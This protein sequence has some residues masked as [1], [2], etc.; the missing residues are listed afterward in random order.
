V[1]SELTYDKLHLHLNLLLN[2]RHLFDRVLVVD[3]NQFQIQKEN[4]H[5]FDRVLVVDG[6]QF[7]IQKENLKE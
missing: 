7:Q 3:G 1:Q 2:W 4:F 5:L 6:N